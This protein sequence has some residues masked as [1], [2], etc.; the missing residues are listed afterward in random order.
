[1]SKPGFCWI[2]P[3]LCVNDLVASLEHYEKV[4]GFDR[5]WQW[6]EASAFEEPER[7]TFACVSR[8]EYSLFLCEK[9]QG[10]PG[11]WIC[12]QVR[13]RDELETLFEE[14]KASG[15]TIIEEPQ[16]CSWG[17]REMVVQDLDRNTFRIG[18]PIHRV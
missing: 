16:D 10:N 15:A 17:M 13:T 14:Y 2:T 11:A 12:L 7:P 6:S 8:G 9:G 1:M 4:L 18:T 3:V 5:T